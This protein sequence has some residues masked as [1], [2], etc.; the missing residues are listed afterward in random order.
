MPYC[1]RC[2]HQNPEGSNYCARCGEPLER[3][4]PQQAAEA[5]HSG[6]TTKV[7]PVIPDETV[8]AELSEEDEAAV[9]ALPV[10]SALLVVRRGAGEGS[11]FLVD[12]DVTT[13]GRHPNSDIFFDDITVSRHHA[14]FVR[15]PDGVDVRDQGSLNGT[16]VNRTRID[17][18]TT[19]K[20]G[21]EVQIGKFRMIFFASLR[22]G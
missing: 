10:G 11:R 14:E 6:D 21:D 13:V 7:I 15:T 2:G 19:L 4:A 16:Y 22:S 8:L 9:D 5:G 12:S 3:T 1:T 17:G 18:E 20:S